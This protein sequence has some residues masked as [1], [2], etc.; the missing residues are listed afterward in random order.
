MRRMGHGHDHHSPDVDAAVS[1]GRRTRTVLL[2]CLTVAALVTLVGLVALWPSGK[3]PAKIPYATKGTTFVDGR[4]AA[5]RPA[6]RDDAAEATQAL[7]CDAMRVDV[8]GDGASPWIRVPPETLSSGLGPGDPVQLMKMPSAG[9]AAP[10]YSYVQPRRLKPLIVL[11]LLFAVVVAAVARVRGVLALVG[12]GFAGFVIVSFMLPALFQGSSGVLVG[13]V[14]SSAI[15]FVVL[16]LAH[17]VSLR[18]SAALAGT[19]AGVLVTTVVG[20]FGAMGA[21]LTG[22][23]SED[24]ATLAAVMHPFD[25]HEMLTCAIIVAGLGVLNDVTI[26]Q[27]SAVW[28][29]RAASPSMNAW[30]LFTAGMRIGRD[31]IAS[32]IYTIAFAYAGAALPVLLLMSVIDRSF[33]DHLQHE[34]VSTEIVSTLASAIGLVLAVPLTTAIAAAVVGESR[35]TTPE[36][37]HAASGGVA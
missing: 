13:L 17:G 7:S 6:C 28:E 34:S 5:M 22:V 20:F 14:G 26:T 2:G 9:G 27:A 11:A 29:L 33:L 3:G 30:D 19:L 23:S 10:T 32:T 37:R 16:Y 12:L 8:K 24:G 15:M 21:R 36:G 4:V 31:H 18:T 25:P 1:V 35:V